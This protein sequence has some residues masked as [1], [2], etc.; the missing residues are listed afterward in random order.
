MPHK[1]L[2]RKVQGIIVQS[3]G[4][5]LLLTDEEY[6]N[7][8]KRFAKKFADPAMSRDINKGCKK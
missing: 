8:R 1:I 5:T 2:L 3:D 4:V 6:N 7:G